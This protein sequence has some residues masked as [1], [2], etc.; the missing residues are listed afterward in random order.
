MLRAWAR[1]TVTSASMPAPAVVM[2][3]PSWVHAAVEPEVSVA[4]IP[5]TR[6]TVQFSG[7]R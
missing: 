3:G 1:T 2:N 6:I 4:L 7:K 5:P